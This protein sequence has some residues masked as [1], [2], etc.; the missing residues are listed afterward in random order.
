[1]SFGFVTKDYRAK[2]ELTKKQLAI[3]VGETKHIELKI[4]TVNQGG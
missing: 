4:N 1:M 3:T 2:H